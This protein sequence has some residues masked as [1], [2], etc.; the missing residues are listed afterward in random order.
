MHR[1]WRGISKGAEAIE[2]QHPF[3]FLQAKGVGAEDQEGHMSIRVK[4]VTISRHTD[5]NFKIEG[6]TRGQGGQLPLAEERIT[7]AHGETML[8]EHREVGPKATQWSRWRGNQ[9][10]QA[11]AEEVEAEDAAN[12]R[13]GEAIGMEQRRERV[14]GP[15]NQSTT[16]CTKVQ[17][18]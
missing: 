1:S 4:R 15:G 3:N 9:I 10:K 2:T 13:Q 16:R 12:H 6:Q 17:T 18:A 7:P 14:L 11:E 5:E 8:R